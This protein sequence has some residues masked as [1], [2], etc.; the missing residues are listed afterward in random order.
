MNLSSPPGHSID[1][2][3]CPDRF[4]ASV[5]HLASM[6]LSEGQGCFMVKADIREAYI[7]LFILR[8]PITSIM[9][10]YLVYIDRTFPFGLHLL[11]NIFSTVAD[12]IQWI[13]R[14]KGI[15]GNIIHYLNDYI[16]VAK[17]KGNTVHQNYSWCP[18]SQNWEFQKNS[19][20]LKAHLSAC[21]FWV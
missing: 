3:I 19:L 20:S 5:D 12:A 15:I 16:L 1:D 8:L 21:H 6:M 18:P 13:L 4:Y 11:P 14:Y 17:E 7:Q 9:W 2:R 10:Q